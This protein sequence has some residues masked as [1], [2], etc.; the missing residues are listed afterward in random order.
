MKLRDPRLRVGLGALAHLPEQLEQGEEPR[1]GADE[2]PF[3]ERPEPRDGLLGRGGQIEPGL[4][5]V[6]SVE[7][8]EPPP[9]RGRPV[10][11]IVERGPRKRVRAEA[12]AKREQRVF[13]P[14][15]QLALREHAFVGGDERAMQEARDERGVVRAQQAPG[16][17][18]LPKVVEGVVVEI[19]CA[20]IGRDHPSRLISS[21][22]ARPPQLAAQA[23]D[24]FL[25][26][27]ADEGGE[28]QLDD[29]AL[30]LRSGGAHCA[31]REGCRQ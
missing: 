22:V 2:A 17:M 13:Q 26:L 23:A 19:P 31:S 28:A 7:L 6:V 5:G 1:L 9:L 11:Q 14:F 16:G 27:Q 30:G 21:Q 3:G 8:A 24:L 18:V 25:L 20:G 29:L 10:V 12:L 4:V 15:G